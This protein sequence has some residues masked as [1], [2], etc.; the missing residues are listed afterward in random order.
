MA[1]GAVYIFGV[2]LYRNTAIVPGPLDTKGTAH[3]AV[4]FVV[5]LWFFVERLALLCSRLA[6]GLADWEQH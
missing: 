4:R 6:A 2:H 5:G 1:Y 3:P